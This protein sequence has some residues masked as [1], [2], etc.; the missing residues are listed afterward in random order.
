MSSLGLKVETSDEKR[1]L[2][3]HLTT[4]WSREHLEMERAEVIQE[5]LNMV[6]ATDSKGI[7]WL[8]EA[9]I[10]AHRW[11]Y[12]QSSEPGASAHLPRFVEAGDAWGEPIGTGGGAM[13]SGAWAAAHIAWQCSQHLQPNKTPVQQTLF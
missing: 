5:F 12:G 8:K 11:R 13:R 2:V 9:T 4:D 7:D 3:V 10:Q 6:E 1:G